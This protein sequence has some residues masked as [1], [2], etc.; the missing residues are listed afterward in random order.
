MF[1]TAYKCVIN[2]PPISI[3][4]NIVLSR[5]TDIVFI[6]EQYLSPMKKYFI[7]LRVT[8]ASTPRCPLDD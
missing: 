5:Y 8:T 1:I 7:L 2:Y 3:N 4:Y 6:K